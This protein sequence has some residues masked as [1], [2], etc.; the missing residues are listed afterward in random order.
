MQPLD[1]AVHEQV[2][3]VEFCQI[4]VGKRLIFGPEP[5]TALRLNSDLPVSSA[6]TA[7]I[8]RVDKPR[9]YISTASASSSSVRPPRIARIFERN[10]SA[11]SAICGALYS[12]APSAVFSRPVRYPFR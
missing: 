7:S 1:D 2:D 8:S 9:A 10:G 4:P 3:E 6:N 5:L 12:T 11:R